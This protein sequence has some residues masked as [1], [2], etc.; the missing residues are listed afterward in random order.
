M[1]IETHLKNMPTFETDRLILRKVA[2]HDLDD[3][4]EFSS[5]PEVAKRMTW[6]KNDS[7]EETLSNFLQPTVDGYKQGQSGVWAIEYKE[8]EKDLCL[9]PMQQQYRWMWI[10][11]YVH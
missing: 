6:E 5:D 11:R 10:P 9:L 8:I 3:V 2:E 1:H 7:K 4:F